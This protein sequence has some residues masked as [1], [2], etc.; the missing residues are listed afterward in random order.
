M[1][2]N[3]MANDTSTLAEKH[4]SMPISLL[5]NRGILVVLSSNFFGKTFVIDKSR[6]VIGRLDECDIA[7]DDPRISKR[8]CEI[9]FDKDDKFYIEDIGSKN[10]TFLNGKKIKK[11]FHLIYG[12]RIIV[13]S[14][15]MRFY[16]EERIKE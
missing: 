8:H 16:L 11:K 10:F 15:I 4:N 9:I 13:G 7:I 14:T 1:S 5:S 6:M 12:D 2:E 3:K